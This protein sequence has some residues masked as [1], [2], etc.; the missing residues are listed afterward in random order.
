MRKAVKSAWA[1][2]NELELKKKKEELEDGVLDKEI[3]WVEDWIN[4]TTR[5][6]HIWESRQHEID[7]IREII[8]DPD[9]KRMMEWNKTSNP[10]TEDCHVEAPHFWDIE[11]SGKQEVQVTTEKFE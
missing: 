2:K 6:V 11:A 3:E 1:L 8:R 10:E 5:T 7:S 4:I 9:W